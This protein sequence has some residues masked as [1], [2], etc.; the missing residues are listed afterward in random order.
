VYPD[1]D[2]FPP[3]YVPQPANLQAGDVIDRFGTEYGHYFAPDGAPAGDR[4]LAPE[5]FFGQ[6]ER[7]VRTGEPLPHGWQ[8]VEGPVQPFYGQ[9]PS[10]DAKQYLILNSD[11]VKLPVWEA[12][13]DSVISYEGPPLGR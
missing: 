8:I 4:S 7:Y 11:G 1:N 12:V 10:P 2:G 6:Y 3:G 5:S 9:A 13:R